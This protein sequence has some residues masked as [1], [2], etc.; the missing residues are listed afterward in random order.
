[1]TDPNDLEARRK[2]LDD[3]LRQMAAERG[4]Q[5]PAPA[6]PPPQMGPPTE[7]ILAQL[8][9]PAALDPEFAA[10]QQADE[11]ASRMRE[12]RDR[13]LRYAAMARGV[14]P[15]ATFESKP[16]ADAVRKYLERKQ[17]AD[18]DP[19][20]A[21]LRAMLLERAKHPNADVERG[22][23]LAETGKIGTE[24]GKIGAETGK[25]KAEVPGV[26]AETAAKVRGNQK[27]SPELIAYA[28]SLGIKT[29]TDMTNKEAKDRI[30][31][32]LKA[33]GLDL[34]AEKVRDAKGTKGADEAAK[35]RK[36]F[37]A[38]PPVQQALQVKPMYD[39]LVS[40]S[41]TGPGDI[42][43]L[44]AYMRIIDPG[45]TVR[46]GEFQQ[47][48]Q[49]GA[50]GD[51]MQGFV[52]HI[53]NGGRLSPKIREQFKEEA[54]RIYDA[55]LKGMKD[56]ADQYRDLAT[57]SNLSPGDVVLEMFNSPEGPAPA[58]QGSSPTPFVPK[59]GTRVQ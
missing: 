10:A 21:M 25:I 46:E 43:L 41:N 27:A 34:E 1:M 28:K 55:Q 31:E 45:S 32:A 23:I 49:A 47:A 22:K 24:V 3:A 16:V 37:N 40:A 30:D 38:L 52:N 4:E 15:G 59:R 56:V 11:A 9:K 51:R 12:A 33:R 8:S 18:S 50:L 48:A 29:T 57:R 35:L 14:E 58:S 26:E 5:I 6:A 7:E 2:M 36:E 13:G 39:K 19:Q 42:S 20:R 44:Y 17:I 54:R 53:V